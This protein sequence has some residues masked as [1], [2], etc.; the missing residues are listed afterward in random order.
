MRYMKVVKY[1]NLTNGLEYLKEIK[2]YKIVRIQSTICEAK[3]W[4]KLIQDLDYNFLMDLAQGN[5]IEIYDTSSKKRISR[6]LFQGVEFIKYALNRR[7]FD[8]E[9]AQA[10]VKEQNVTTY[11]KYEYERLSKNAK[12]KLD[13]IKK[14]LNA[15]EV[16][17]E[18]FC[19][20]T[21]HDGDYIYFKE[22]LNEEL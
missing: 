11:F 19:R 7:W 14:F 5:K 15:N 20:K 21:E 13:Y 4:D 12:S 17:I 2:D 16:N 6:A 10:M 9:N 22:L 18:T 1:L 3:N 8:N